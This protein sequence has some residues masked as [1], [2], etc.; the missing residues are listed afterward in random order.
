MYGYH[1]AARIHW[2]GNDTGNWFYIKNDNNG[3]KNI[4]KTWSADY[5]ITL[6]GYTDAGTV[7]LHYICCGT[8]DGTYG[9]GCNV[10]WADE[11]VASAS[12]GRAY[13]PSSIWLNPN[14]YTKISKVN[15][16]SWSVHYS[17]NAGSVSNCPISLA[18]HD[19]DRTS[20]GVRWEPVLRYVNGS[21]D[22]V[23]D[24]YTLGTDRG[25]SDGQR[26]RITLVSNGGEALSPNSWDPRQGLVIYT[27][28]IPTLNNS[29]T[30]SRTSQN[31]NQDNKFTI[32]GTN[33][34]AWSSYEN[35]FVTRYRVKR[36]S[37]SYTGWTS[38]GNVTSWSRNASEVRS[39][40]PKAYDGQNIILQMERWSTVVNTSNTIYESSNKPTVTF[41]VYYRPRIAIVGNDVS[42][43]DSNNNNIPKSKIIAKSKLTDITV[44]WTYD[45]NQALAGYTQGYRIRLYNKAGTVVKTYYTSNKSYTIPANDI[46][47]NGLLTYIDVTPY[48]C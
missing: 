9:H 40:A 14:D 41:V 28:R 20:W 31:A 38:I 17:Y 45:T 47:S 15:E 27:Y 19:Y 39:L 48:L 33:N 3:Y 2:N 32:S 8:G 16:G 36:G 46:P 34:R 23:W 44:T 10:G 11:E 29:I 5:D 21:S 13:T 42:Y 43:K 30:A 35:E 6:W 25:F 26:Y 7:S 12:I 24:S 18:I 4:D 22:G 37:A 1:Y